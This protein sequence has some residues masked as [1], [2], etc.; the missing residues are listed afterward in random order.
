MAL[1]IAI[2]G[3]GGVARGNYLPHLS[4]AEDVDLTY[5]SRTVAKAEACATDFGGG[6][7]GSLEELM[8]GDPDAVLLLTMETDRYEAA[9]S[10]LEHRPRRLFFE[11]P[12]VARAGQANVSEEDFFLGKEVLAKAE[13][14]GTETAM[15]FNYRFFE[16]SVRGLALIRD[17]N[18][19]ALTQASL[20]VN[21]CCWSHCIDLL[22]CF[23]G[24]PQQI[25]ALSGPTEFGEGAQKGVDI[26]GAFT[27]ESGG[28]G[29][30]VGTSGTAFSSTLYEMLLSFENGIMRF[31]DLDGEL[32]LFDYQTGYTESISLGPNR[33]RWDQYGDSF[34]SS[35]N[36]YLAS[37][38]AG[39][40]APVPGLAG[41][42]EL[43]T[44]AALRRSAREQRPV[45]VQEEFSINLGE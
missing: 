31:N 28:C 15:V 22:H 12:L 42:A 6:V 30:I 40:P 41:L 34:V 1:K 43:Q 29:T 4:K 26:A 19:G 36:A 14:V 10:V 17:R 5:Y 13:E 38:R 20:L 37:I 39:G 24:S 21:Y 9:M 2:V 44:E 32:K 45:D 33:S 7:A 35:L 8:A 18:L 25:T 3:P 27:L 11:K 23:G 16:L